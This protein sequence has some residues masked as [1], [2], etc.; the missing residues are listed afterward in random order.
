[1]KDRNLII[2]YTSLI[3][4]HFLHIIEE[5]IGNVSFIYTFY[6]GVE[7]FLV[8]N[9]ALLI[10]SIIIFYFTMK[11]KKWAYYLSYVYSAIMII[12]GFSHI[13]N[14][15]VGSYTGILLILLGITLIFSLKSY[16]V[17]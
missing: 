12:D 15:H 13:L 7:M 6:K 10:I 3:I 1:M 17:K 5:L 9:I 11:N 16:K 14:Y 2:F 8:V 4:I